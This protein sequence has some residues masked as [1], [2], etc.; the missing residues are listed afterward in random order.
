[1]S[2]PCIMQV[3]SMFLSILA[4][5]KVELIKQKRREHFN[6][7]YKERKILLYVLKIEEAST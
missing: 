5:G 3:N 2:I 4:A 1:M 6:T 7:E